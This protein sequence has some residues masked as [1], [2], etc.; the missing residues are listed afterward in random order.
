MR[1]STWLLH[2]PRSILEGGKCH[3]EKHMLVVRAR[4][5]RLDAI[6]IVDVQPKLYLNRMTHQTIRCA[7]REGWHI[8][9]K[10]SLQHFP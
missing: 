6:D 8:R 9:L 5:V 4:V 3:K 1:M 7:L 2:S 10:Q